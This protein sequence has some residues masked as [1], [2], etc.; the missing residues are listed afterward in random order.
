LTTLFNTGATLGNH[1]ASDWSISCNSKPNP[2]L[3]IST[4][5]FFDLILYNAIN[6][7]NVIAAAN[8]HK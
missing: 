7:K 6:Y 1:L 2:M 5:N 4:L 3:F 8:S